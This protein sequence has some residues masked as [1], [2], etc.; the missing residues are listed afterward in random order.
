MPCFWVR[1]FN[2]TSCIVSFDE[3]R[4]DTGR[5]IR[6]ILNYFWGE[7]GGSY[8]NPWENQAGVSFWSPIEPYIPSSS[9]DEFLTPH[10]VHVSFS[11]SVRNA[12]ATPQ[13]CKPVNFLC[14]EQ[15]MNTEKFSLRKT[16][17]PDKS[18]ECLCKDQS[19]SSES[20]ISQCWHTP[21]R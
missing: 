14:H 8:E 21:L 2:W 12:Q 6:V 19:V 7:G 15:Q 4:I 16:E 1:V 9:L 11:R 18:P 5:Q 13:L 20:G 3:R 17:W 10:Y